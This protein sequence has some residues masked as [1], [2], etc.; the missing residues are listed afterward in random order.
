MFILSYKPT[1]AADKVPSPALPP[2]K[3]VN[4]QIDFLY[5]DFPGK[6][7]IYEVKKSSQYDISETK[8]VRNKKD[9]PIL[10]NLK[11]RF[12]LLPGKSKTFVLV[13][14]N[15]TNID[16]YFNATPHSILPV[17]STVGQ[18]FE[19][20]CNHSIY[21]ADKKSYW[22]RIV[23]FEL[24]KSFEGQSIR[25]THNIIGIKEADA[26]EKYNEMLFN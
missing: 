20:L 13:V 18:K 10:G 15:K 11:G 19:C 8:V 5:H 1:L 26:K 21:K 9:L 16:W 3:P 14:E 25:L 4:V 6:V 2:S 23:R 22:Y 7:E 24:D 12:T 17:E